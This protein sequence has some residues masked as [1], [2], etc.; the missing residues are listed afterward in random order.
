MV[1]EILDFNLLKICVTNF[2]ICLRDSPCLVIDP[3]GDKKLSLFAVFDG[4]GGNQVADFAKAHFIEE[5]EASENYKGG[6]FESALK[7]TFVRMDELMNTEEGE[8][9]LKTYTQKED[10]SNFGA[11]SGMDPTGNIAMSCGCTACVCLIVKDETSYQVYWANAGDSRC[12]LS[13]D[14]LAVS[15]SDDHKPSLAKEEERIK[16]AKGYVEADR[17]NGSLNLSRALGDFSYKN[18]PELALDEQ[19]VICIPEVKVA[20]I[21]EKTQF[22]IIACDG[23]WDWMTNEV[24]IEFIHEQLRENSSTE[25]F[26]LSSINEA[27][28]EKNIALDTFGTSTGS[29]K[30]GAG[31]D[32]MTSI[33]VKLKPLESGTPDQEAAEES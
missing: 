10:E 7:E 29:G 33:I 27:I 17:V 21:D 4:H 16:N 19:Q 11:Y 3:V 9:E 30:E 32:N 22:L 2:D 18:N 26:K 14:S 25:G 12:V 28:F 6:D 1:I 20:T 23:I 8:E 15:L 24:A 13:Q 31:C 5:L